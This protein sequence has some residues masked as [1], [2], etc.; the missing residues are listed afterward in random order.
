M[1]QRGITDEWDWYGRN[2]LWPNQGIKLALAWT[3]SGNSWKTSI[4]RDGVPAEIQTKHLLKMSREHY[5]YTNWFD[6]L[7]WPGQ[8][9]SQEMWFCFGSN[10][11]SQSMKPRSTE[12]NKKWGRSVNKDNQ[13]RLVKR[14]PCIWQKPTLP[15]FY[16]QSVV[17]WIRW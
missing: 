7:G 10:E 6:E 3:D 2:W 15:Y 11:P 1:L 4:I 8:R 13:I 12:G 17:F 9:F 16:L 14:V 5:C